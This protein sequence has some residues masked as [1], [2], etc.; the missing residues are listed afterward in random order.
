MRVF[1]CVGEPCGA[2][3]AVR[4]LAGCPRCGSELKEVGVAKATSGG[5]SNAREPG[6]SVD[7]LVAEE[8]GGA[9][10]RASAVA[11]AISDGSADATAAARDDAVADAAPDEGA[12][13]AGAG[14]ARPASAA[15]KADW[16]AWAI[17]AGASED[18]AEGMTKVAL[19]QWEPPA[20]GDP[21]AEP[22]IGSQVTITAEAEVT[23]G[24]PGEE[25]G[26]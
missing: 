5:A 23:R 17:G 9:G 14:P 6:E 12:D 4:L 16:V 21:G 19:M 8:D 22:S 20:P 13:A 3:Y 18:E 15:P 24:E 1:K 26:E 25:G 11:D 7:V 10:A 2:E